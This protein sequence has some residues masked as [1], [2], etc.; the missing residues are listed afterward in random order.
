M[1]PPSYEGSTALSTIRIA[2]KYPVPAPGR[3]GERVGHETSTNSA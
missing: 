3:G 2:C 1:T